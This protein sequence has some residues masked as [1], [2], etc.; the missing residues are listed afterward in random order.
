MPQT[1]DLSK[2]KY[3]TQAE[4]LG[5]FRDRLRAAC[6]GCND[7][8]C[9]VSDQPVPIVIPAGGGLCVTVALG[10]GSYNQSLFNGA[11]HTALNEDSQVI[12][13]VMI[14]SM[15]DRIPAADRALLSDDRG[16]ISVV[17]RNA[18]RALLVYSPELGRASQNWEPAVGDR[19]LC[20]DQ[21]RP[22]RCSAPADVPDNPGWIGLQITFSAS[23]DWELY[24]E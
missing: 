8:T 11:G 4:V 7:Q 17:K 3:A 14:N 21:I 10:D 1:L 15:I 12:V 6:P 9:F 24:S 13:T 16:L 22:L 19:P 18:L 20:R 2:R 5:A 23:F